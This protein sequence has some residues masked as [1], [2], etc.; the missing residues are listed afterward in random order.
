MI[1][2]IIQL[3]CF[4][5]GGVVVS[6]L[7][8]ELL[9][10]FS[11]SLGIRNKNDVIVRWSNESKPSLG[12]VSFF[13]VFVFTAIGYSI[14]F[15]DN[16][17]HNQKY[18]GLI[19]AGSIAFL[20]GLADDAYNT[21]P[22]AKLI[23]QIVCG[24]IL[25]TTDVNINLFHNIYLDSLITIIWVV[26]IMNSL[27]MLDNMDGITGT[28]VFFILLTCL[29]SNWIVLDF[30]SNIWTVSL[31]AML[32]AVVGFLF[33][34]VHPSKL[35]M[36]DAGSQFIGLFVA[37]Y[38]IESLWSVGHG[39]GHYECSWWAGAVVTLIAFT[40]AAVDT[41]TVVI[42]RLKKGSS[43][44][45]GGKDHTT[46]HLVYAGFNDKGVWYVFVSLGAMSS[47]LAVSLINLVKLG[48]LIPILFSI[49]YFGIVFWMLYRNTIKFQTPKKSIND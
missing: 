18:I 42:N 17:F 38:S 26:G 43:P 37:F 11:K 46:H 35:F 33:Y 3:I 40:P 2:K 47:L 5:L 32:G 49:I 39:V 16:I 27:N 1:L 12:G 31:I 20:M 41:L 8:N 24:I 48:I 4:C 30:N 22:Y 6:A 9:L 10:R 15:E 25:T 14:V 13:V 36:G 7:C 34:N 44:M 29:A 45:V 23:I 28:T 19:L 21:R